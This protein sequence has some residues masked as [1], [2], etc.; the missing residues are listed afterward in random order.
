MF[1]YST[2]IPVHQPFEAVMEV[3]G[4]KTRYSEQ[5]MLPAEADILLVTESSLEEDSE[6]DDQS[7]YPPKVYA[8]TWHD[9]VSHIMHMLPCSAYF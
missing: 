1:V 5:T 6:A 9:D 4:M 7:Y 3:S 2:A 8:Q